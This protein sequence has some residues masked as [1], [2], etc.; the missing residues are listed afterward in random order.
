[1]IPFWLT[2]RTE[3]QKAEECKSKE[4]EKPRWINLEFRDECEIR[5]V[6][7]NDFVYYEFEAQDENDDNHETRL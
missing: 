3:A 6:Y 4:K 5:N 7:N 1:M 2:V